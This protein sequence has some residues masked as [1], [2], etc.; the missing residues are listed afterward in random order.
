MARTL[1]EPFGLGALRPLWT[2]TETAN[3][4]VVSAKG[5]KESWMYVD[6]VLEAEYAKA[7]ASSRKARRWIAKVAEHNLALVEGTGSEES[8]RQ[9]GRAIVEWQ[10]AIRETIRACKM[11]E[12]RYTKIISGG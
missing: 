3:A 2:R 7:Y 9:L 4:R 11:F 8:E 1:T 5:L 12:D 6:E 10:K